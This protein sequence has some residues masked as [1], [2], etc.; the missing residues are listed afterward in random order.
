[1]EKNHGRSLLNKQSKYQ[2]HYHYENYD[3]SVLTYLLFRNDNISKIA[4]KSSD[5]LLVVEDQS[6]SI[7]KGQLAGILIGAVT[8][9]P[10][11]IERAMTVQQNTSFS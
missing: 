8:V 5:H 11:L 6:Y 7:L 4:F 2:E 10:L 3:S 9:T 1:M